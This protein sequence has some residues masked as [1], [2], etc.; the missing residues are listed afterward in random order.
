M[1]DPEEVTVTAIKCHEN[2]YVVDPC[3]TVEIFGKDFIDSINA[4]LMK[5]SLLAAHREHKLLR[6]DRGTYL[7]QLRELRE[8][9]D[10]RKL[11]EER[12]AWQVAIHA[13]L[14]Y[15]LVAS[16]SSKF[17]ALQRGSAALRSELE[18]KF[19]AAGVAENT[20]LRQNTLW[21]LRE[22]PDRGA[23]KQ[24]LTDVVER[25]PTVQLNAR[26]LLQLPEAVNMALQKKRTLDHTWPWTPGGRGRSA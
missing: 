3:L 24:L 14:A 16:Y 23:L 10:Q 8:L 12:L 7:K 25:I 18:A 26:K 2:V 13:Q 6:D 19:Q 5:S 9:F 21:L 1:H 15:A 4:V 20:A 17:A 11:V 22:F